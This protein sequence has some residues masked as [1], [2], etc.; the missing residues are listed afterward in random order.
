[1][2]CTVEDCSKPIQYGGLCPMHVARKRRTG[3]TDPGPC[4]QLPA[5]ERFWNKVM[6]TAGCW[7]WTGHRNNHGYGAFGAVKSKLVYA[8]RFSYE[9]AYGPIPPGLV[10]RHRC[11]TPACVRPD[12][13]EIG[14]QRENIQDAFDRHRAVRD[15]KTGR[16]ASPSWW[17]PTGN[18]DR[19]GPSWI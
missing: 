8:H 3:T 7:Y 1:M 2:T 9:L 18:E 17:K 11:D 5:T 16:L 10:V 14:T 19:E 6:K 13:L 12:H 15:A 4:A